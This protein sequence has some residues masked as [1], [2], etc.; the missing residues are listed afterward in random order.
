MHVAVQWHWF[1]RNRH[2]LLFYDGR[3]FMFAKHISRKKS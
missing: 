1:G 2:G 3:E